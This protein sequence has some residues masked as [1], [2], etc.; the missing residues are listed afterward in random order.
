[1][2]YV[3]SPVDSRNR[4]IVFSFEDNT[5]NS[6]PE[7]NII[8]SVPYGND[9]EYFSNDGLN[10]RLGLTVDMD[11]RRSYH[12]VR[13]FALESNLSVVVNYGERIYPSAENA[14]KPS[15]LSLIH[16]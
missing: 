16:I 8:V 1:M 7:N 9:I 15:I 14:Y 10:N 5:E 13:D 6:N 2:D 11:R 12:S 4:P 3:E